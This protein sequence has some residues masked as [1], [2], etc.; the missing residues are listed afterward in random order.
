ME[1]LLS[2]E[3]QIETTRSGIKIMASFEEQIV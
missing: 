2:F 1:S 3:A